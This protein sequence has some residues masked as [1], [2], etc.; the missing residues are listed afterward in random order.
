[1]P[2]KLK[3]EENRNR[4]RQEDEIVDSIDGIVWEADARTFRFSFVS[5]QAE[6]L[7]SY[8]IDQWLNDPAF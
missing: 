6:R 3:P 8:P 7:L 4:K 2:D 5:K 1:M